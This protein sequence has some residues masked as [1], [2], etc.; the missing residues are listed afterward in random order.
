MN[1]KPHYL[2]ELQAEPEP[3]GMLSSTVVT[4]IFP[5]YPKWLRQNKTSLTPLILLQKLLNNFCSAEGSTG[6]C[7]DRTMD[8]SGFSSYS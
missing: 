8:R 3:I 4:N 7:G 2:Y 6:A 5:Q 1:A